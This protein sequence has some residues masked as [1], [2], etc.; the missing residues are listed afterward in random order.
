MSTTGAGIGRTGKRSAL[1]CGFSFTYMLT[2]LYM[3]YCVGEPSWES[4]IVLHH[5]L[6][7]AGLSFALFSTHQTQLADTIILYESTGPLFHAHHYLLYLNV[8]RSNL[9]FLLNG[10][11][12]FVA[13]A[14]F[15]IY[16]GSALAIHFIRDKKAKNSLFVLISILFHSLSLYWFYI[17]LCEMCSVLCSLLGNERLL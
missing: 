1:F 12:F 13:F 14:Y 17:I 5:T 8:E 10:F 3:M 11:A 16:L 2:D 15:R 7:I 4:T 9:L 6:C